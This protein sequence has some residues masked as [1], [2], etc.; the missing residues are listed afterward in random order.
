MILNVPSGGNIANFKSH[1]VAVFLEPN[2]NTPTLIQTV[3]KDNINKISSTKDI[4]TDGKYHTI[5]VYL[6]D[7]IMYFEIDGEQI[8]TLATLGGWGPANLIFGENGFGGTIKN[9]YVN[10]TI[11]S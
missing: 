3:S 9:L 7:T 2:S 4:V 8:G 5:N 11:I 6:K 1:G 10:N